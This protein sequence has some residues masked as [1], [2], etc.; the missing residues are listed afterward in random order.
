MYTHACVCEDTGSN[1]W[2]LGTEFN[3]GTV[4]R[5]VGIVEG[6]QERMMNDPGTSD[7]W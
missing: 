2:V 1:G 5:A 6:K 4:C 7:S 3:E